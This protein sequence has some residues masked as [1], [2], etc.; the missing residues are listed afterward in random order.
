MICRR[1]FRNEIRLRV[2]GIAVVTSVLVKV[3]CSHTPGRSMPI[4]SRSLEWYLH[5]KTEFHQEKWC[6]SMWDKS[7]RGGF[8]G[9]GMRRGGLQLMVSLTPG[10][11]CAARRITVA[12]VTFASAR[13]CQWRH[14]HLYG[15]AHG[16]LQCER[17]AKAFGRGTAQK[18]IERE[19]VRNGGATEERQQ[20][21]IQKPAL[22]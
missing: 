3:R 22:F 9:Y 15:G 2:K 12:E 8:G 6:S 14:R 19:K 4:G 1:S 13:L 5:G 16:A 21:G 10:R 18:L 17:V 20:S 11:S 7:Q